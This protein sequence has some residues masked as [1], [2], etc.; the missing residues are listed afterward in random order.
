LPVRQEITLDDVS[1]RYGGTDRPTLDGVA[2]SIP[3]NSS[4]AFVGPTGSGKSTLIDILVGLLQPHEG[5][6]RVDGVPVTAENVRSWQAS[7]GYVPQEAMLFDDTVLRNIVFGVEDE[8]VDRGRVERAARIARIH[9]FIVNELPNGYETVVGERGIRLSGGQRQ[10]MGL[11]RALYREPSVL[12]LDEATSA[13]DGVTEREVMEAIAGMRNQ[14]TLIL[15]AHRLTTVRDCD[16]IYLLDGGR[17][18]DEGTYG[19]LIASNHLFRGMAKA[20]S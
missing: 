3:R 4:V 12:I 9:D 20:V 1:F 16:R 11:A 13:L 8:D 7:I 2:L 10:R 15:V 17:I 18:T 6:V 5:C 14:V 19:D